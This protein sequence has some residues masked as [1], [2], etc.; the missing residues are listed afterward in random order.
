M[1]IYIYFLLML[2]EMFILLGVSIY[3][4]GLLFS[5][6]KGA[7]YVPTS[8]KQ[9]EKIFK[10]I[11][12]KNDELFVELGSGDG[13]LVRYAAKKY[14]IR[15]I[16]IEINPLLVWWSKLLSK[17]DGTSEKV[18]FLKKNVFDY[19]LTQANY[20]YIFLMPELIQK[21]LPKFKKELKG[22]TIIISHGFKIIGFEKRLIH[23]EPD[24]TFST[25]YYKV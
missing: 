25:Y 22:G 13:R 3:G 6:F 24:K 17:R 20:L 11:S 2:L 18:Q 10:N 7:P 19:P 21:L 15:G 16:G 4:V 9:L 12:P 1:T 14:D 8:K 23:M 5:S